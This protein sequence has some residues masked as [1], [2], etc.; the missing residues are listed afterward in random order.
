VRGNSARAEQEAPGA[1]RLALGF[2]GLAA[3]AAAAAAGLGALQGG[4][5]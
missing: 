4:A 2:K 1:A 3:A 5:A